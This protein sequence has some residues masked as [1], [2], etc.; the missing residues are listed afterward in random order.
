M[1]IAILK[2]VTAALAVLCCCSCVS[3]APYKS[4]IHSIETT[5]CAGLICS[6][7]ANTSELPHD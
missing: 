5:L 7:C 2:S 1:V 6:I 4:S 3:Q